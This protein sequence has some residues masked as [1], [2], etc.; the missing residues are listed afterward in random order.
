MKRGGLVMRQ[1]KKHYLQILK[2]EVEDLREDL[3]L[4]IEECR[5]S[6]QME[7]ITEH[8]FLANL[9]LFR[10][11][12]LGLEEFSRIV[13]TTECDSFETLET[14]MDYLRKRFREKMSTGG[15]AEALYICI[16]RKLNK[17]ARYVT[18]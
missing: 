2:I 11:E 8:V 14:M 17:V 10:N 13:D 7:K 16:E 5:K 4:M 6:Y 9:T 18:Q 15:L 1:S 12:L 3:E